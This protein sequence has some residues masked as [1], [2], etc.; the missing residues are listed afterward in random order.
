MR[1]IS[2]IIAMMTATIQSRC[3]ATDVTA[4]VTRAIIQRMIS[5]TA[6]ISN[7]CFTSSNRSNDPV[8]VHCIVK[9]W[10]RAKWFIVILAVLQVAFFASCATMDTRVGITT[11]EGPRL[12]DQGDWY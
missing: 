3:S 5:T 8:H 6:I 7:K 12:T 2:H 9:Q 1:P 11:N 4:R 10:G